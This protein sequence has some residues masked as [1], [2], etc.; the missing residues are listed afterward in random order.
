MLAGSGTITLAQLL[1]A[2]RY[3]HLTHPCSKCGAVVWLTKNTPQDENGRAICSDCNR[4]QITEQVF[5][6]RKNAA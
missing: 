4:N 1:T 3:S 2:E 6:Q 5:S